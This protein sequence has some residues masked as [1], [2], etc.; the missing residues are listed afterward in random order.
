MHQGE[1]TLGTVHKAVLHRVSLLLAPLPQL[2]VG[3]FCR[4]K[5]MSSLLGVDEGRLPMKPQDSVH[6][7]IGQAAGSRPHGQ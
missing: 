4:R 5:S 3:V 7:R 2:S 6:P 1:E